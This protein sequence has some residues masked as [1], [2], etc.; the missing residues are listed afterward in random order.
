MKKK[1]ESVLLWSS[2]HTYFWCAQ[3][4]YWYITAMYTLSCPFKT[5]SFKTISFKTI[6]PCN[7]LFSTY[8]ETCHW[9]HQSGPTHSEAPMTVYAMH[10]III[11]FQMCTRTEKIL[12]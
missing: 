12:I 4:V 8:S 11:N 5:I 7:H 1:I 6:Y 3:C 10:P 2:L 9:I